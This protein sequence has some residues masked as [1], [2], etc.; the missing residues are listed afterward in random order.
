MHL[1]FDQQSTRGTDMFHLFD[2]RCEKCIIP[3]KEMVLYSIILR[4]IDDHFSQNESS[5]FIGREAIFDGLSR[6]LAVD[7]VVEGSDASSLEESGPANGAHNG[8]CSLVL[9]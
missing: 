2:Q 7:V 6:V 4:T 8:L 9:E 5:S 3:N 1:K